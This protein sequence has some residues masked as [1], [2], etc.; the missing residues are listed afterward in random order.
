MCRTQEKTR[1]DI[2]DY[3]KNFFNSKYRHSVSDKTS[4]TEYEHQYYQRVGNI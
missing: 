4:P 1:S 2:L 3:I